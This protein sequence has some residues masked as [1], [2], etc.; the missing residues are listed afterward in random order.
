MGRFGD[1]LGRT[2]PPAHPPPARNQI[3][4]TLG[5]EMRSQCPCLRVPC[6][7]RTEGGVEGAQERANSRPS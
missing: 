1:W 2:P 3:C 4:N 5:P 7:G 6:S